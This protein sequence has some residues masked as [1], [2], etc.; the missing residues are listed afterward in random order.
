MLMYWSQDDTKIVA[1]QEDQIDLGYGSAGY[2][3]IIMNVQ[4]RHEGR[5]VCTVTTL[6]DEASA[7]APLRVLAN[8]P[9][10]TLNT[11]DQVRTSCQCENQ[12][13]TCCLLER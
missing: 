7:V 5:Y 10:I 8:A 3:L 13:L 11:P 2:T 4:A 9:Q 6:R 12:F 1:S